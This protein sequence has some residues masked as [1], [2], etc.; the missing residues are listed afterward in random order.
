[1]T[2]K[3]QHAILLPAIFLATT[4][5][6]CQGFAWILVKTVGPWVPEETAQAEYD[7]KNKSVLV[8]V[9]AK[10]PG[11]LSEYPRLESAISTGIGKQLGERQACGPIVPAHS[12][13]NARRA[14]PQFGQWSVA[15]AG[16][17]FNVDLVMHVEILDFRLRDAPGSNVYHGYVE[18][19][20]RLVSPETGEQVWP[21]LAAARLVTA[22]TQP[23]LAT[24]EH[25]EQETILIEGISDKI[26]RLFYT[27]KIADLPMRPKVK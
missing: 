18:T 17:Y 25:G 11:F 13:D 21:V 16:K 26:A 7:M 19:A 27:Y 12:V 20:V 10:D 24:E 4:L 8:L 22:E 14:E 5:A 3:R 1:V 23:D 2:L 9:D 6:G 15:Q